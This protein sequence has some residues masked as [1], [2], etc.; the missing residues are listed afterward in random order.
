MADQQV[1]AAAEQLSQA[2]EVM[3]RPELRRG[4]GSRKYLAGP[5]PAKW[6]WLGRYSRLNPMPALATLTDAL[7]ASFSEVYSIAELT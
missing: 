7:H 6:P 5:I 1:V 2:L 3:H 4:F